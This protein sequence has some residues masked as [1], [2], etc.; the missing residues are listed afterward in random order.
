MMLFGIPRDHHDRHIRGGMGRVVTQHAR[1]LQTINRRHHHIG[2]DD[3]RQVHAT[4][5]Q[6]DHSILDIVHLRDSQ[7]F[8][9][10]TQQTT[11]MII[12][13]NNKNAKIRN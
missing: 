2:D 10:A 8:Q 4:V 1:K 3:I 12:V 11:H 6:C 5:V 7:S 13:I 9:N